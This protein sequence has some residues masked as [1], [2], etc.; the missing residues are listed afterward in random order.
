MAV[1]AARPECGAVYCGVREVEAATGTVLADT[2]RAYPQGALLDRLLVRDVTAPTSTY[3]LRREV[4]EQ[5]GG[6]DVSL[7]ARQDWDMW[8]RVSERSQLGAVPEPL[9]DL[10]HHSGPRTIS[11][12]FRELEAHRA[13]LGKYARLRRSRGYPVRLAALASYHRRAGRV[14]LH[15]AGAPFVAMRH[16]LLAIAIWPAD[17]D[18]Y[19]ALL[20][21]F[22]P[23]RLR[24]RLHAAWNRVFGRSILSIRSH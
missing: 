2:P 24:R 9:V 20:G 3:V 19:A 11:D 17:P 4:F 13:I 7:Q 14:H 10:R 16:Y 8:I 1:L 5:A 21:W 6:F 15:H 23:P 22:L 18:S 12:P